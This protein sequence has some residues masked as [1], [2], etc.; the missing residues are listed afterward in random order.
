MR[1]L[2]LLAFAITTVQSQAGIFKW[3][4][5]KEKESIAWCEANA[6]RCTNNKAKKGTEYSL[7]EATEFFVKL[8]K[9]TKNEIVEAAEYLNEKAV[10]LHNKVIEINQKS[11]IWCLENP[12]RCNREKAKKGAEYS[13]AQ[14]L[15]FLKAVAK[16]GK[17]AV[18]EVIELGERLL[19]EL[20]ELNEESQ[21][22]CAQNP[23]R[24]MNSEAKKG[25]EYSLKQTIQGL[26]NFLNE[27]K[28]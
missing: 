14:A 16:S 24:C 22:W 26:K 25:T 5:N 10:K 1:Y 12:G 13:A 15:D 19:D 9:A 3:L 21:Q 4:K 6:Q 18:H 27:L 20:V 28:H 7:E 2:I 11:K 8:S 23:G 17:L